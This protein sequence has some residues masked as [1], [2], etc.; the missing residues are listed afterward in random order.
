[1]IANSSND[2]CRLEK[3][4]EEIHNKWHL[5]ISQTV[6]V[7]NNY[8]GTFMTSMGFSGEVELVHSNNIRD[9][10]QYGIQIRVK[11]RNEEKLQQLDRFIQSGGER[12][13][14]IAVYTLS[15]QHISHVPF[16]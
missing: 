1:M 11:Y 14:A 8:F 4:M 3:D 12:A 10:D 6:A 7:I 2:T 15:L 5:S 13:V 9:Y 16:R